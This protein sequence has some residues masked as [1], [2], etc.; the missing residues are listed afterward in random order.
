MTLEEQ[1]T[2]LRLELLAAQAALEE[3]R[4]LLRDALTLFGDDEKV[5]R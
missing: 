4:E 2:Q 3:V 5:V 1:V